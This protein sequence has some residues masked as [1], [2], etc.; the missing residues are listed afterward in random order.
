[1]YS[2]DRSIRE[3]LAHSG[4][5]LVRVRPQ[6]FEVDGETL[7]ELA[8]RVHKTQLAR[9][10][11]EQGKLV[12]D[13]NDG[14]FAR[15]GRR[16]RDCELKDST[17]RPFLRLYLETGEGTALIDLNKPSAER[18]F[19]IEDAVRDAKLDLHKIDL[20]LTVTDHGRWGEV[21]FAFAN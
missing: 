15:N 1:M 10:L 12:C 9:K 7:R 14:E 19:E 11:F 5:R 8:G 3:T 4:L 6:G 20:R 18:L 21:R 16:C 13:S 17:C 2:T